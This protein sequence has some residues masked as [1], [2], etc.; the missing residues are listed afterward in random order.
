MTELLTADYS[1]L[2]ERLAMH[3][4]IPG[5]Y[6]NQFR[7]VTFADDSHGEACLARRAC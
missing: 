1:F 6:G 3:Y 2:N 5:I 7:R 4:G